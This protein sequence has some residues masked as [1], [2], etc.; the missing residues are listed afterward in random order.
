[1]N[2]QDNTLWLYQKIFRK[3]RSDIPSLNGAAITDEQKANLLAATFQN[4]FTNNVVPSPPRTAT[5]SGTI[6]NYDMG[7]R[8]ALRAI[9]PATIY[10]LKSFIRGIIVDF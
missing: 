2:T 1:M 5:S 6:N 7:W 8:L 9:C 10:A 4:N 3:K